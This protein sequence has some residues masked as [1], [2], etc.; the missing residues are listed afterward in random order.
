MAAYWLICFDAE[1]APADESDVQISRDPALSPERARRGLR[2]VRAPRIVIVLVI[3]A[4]TLS[5]PEVLDG[6]VVYELTVR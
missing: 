5:S 2:C 6:H 4:R 3:N 1:H